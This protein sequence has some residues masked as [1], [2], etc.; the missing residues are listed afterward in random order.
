VGRLK[1]LDT[2]GKTLV[3]LSTIL[4]PIRRSP[5]LFKG[6]TR[7]TTAAGPTKYE[8][9]TSKNAAGVILIHTTPA[10]GYGW[11]VVSNRGWRELVH[12]AKGRRPGA[13]VRGWMTG[14]CRV[15]FSRQPDRISTR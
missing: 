7:R 15:S 5:D 4:L 3:M 1:G 13:A 9:G 14:S 6:T 12:E 2:R 11:N 8:I 10:A